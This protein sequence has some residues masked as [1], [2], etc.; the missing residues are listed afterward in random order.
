MFVDKVRKCDTCGMTL[1]H[2]KEFRLC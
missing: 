2:D 1:N